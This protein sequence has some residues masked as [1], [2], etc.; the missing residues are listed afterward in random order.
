LDEVKQQ[1]AKLQAELGSKLT[2]TSVHEG[3]PQRNT[4]TKEGTKKH[5]IK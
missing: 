1:L 3:Q 2:N 4:A 5:H